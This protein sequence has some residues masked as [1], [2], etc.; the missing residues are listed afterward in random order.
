MPSVQ[1]NLLIL[2]LV[3]FD[4]VIIAVLIYL[5][6]RIILQ[7]GKEAKTPAMDQDPAVAKTVEM[8]ASLIK[9]ADQIEVR[10]Q[11]EMA[12]KQNLLKT[13]NQQ[14]DQRIASL[15][16]LLNRADILISDPEIGRDKQRDKQRNIQGD[17]QGDKQND[18]V[19]NRPPE[20]FDAYRR[21]S[22]ARQAS[23]KATNSE[24]NADAVPDLNPRPRR[25]SLPSGSGESPRALSVKQQQT[26][27][28]DLARKGLAVEEIA[29]RMSMPK[30]EVQLMLNLK[31]KPVI[32]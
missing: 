5:G 31:R 17:I 6:R 20:L 29:Q 15:N 13:L 1:L 28:L 4:V 26:K 24:S 23:R 27:I 32:S 21:G 7:S 11:T 16:L 30:G 2:M 19:P 3:L 14:L 12:E 10:L 25:N 22:G 9:E 18:T 8:F